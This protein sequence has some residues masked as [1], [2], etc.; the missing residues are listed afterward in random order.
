MAFTN[1]TYY[2]EFRDD[3]DT[4]HTVYLF[5]DG[6]GGSLTSLDGTDDPLVFRYGQQ[7]MDD[8][9]P[10]GPTSLE[11]SYIASDTTVFDDI[12]STTPMSWLV[13]WETGGSGGGALDGTEVWRGFL[14]TDEITREYD[15]PHVVTLY[16]VDGLKLLENI[17]WAPAAPTTRAPIIEVLADALGELTG[18]G[19]GFGTYAN[20]HAYNGGAAASG[21]SWA[22]YEVQPSAWSD[23]ETGDY[24]SVALACDNMAHAF[25]GHLTL[26]DGKW[27]MMQREA[28]AG[29]SYSMDI[30][31]S[32]GTVSGG[33]ETISRLE[34][35]T[36]AAPI[37]AGAQIQ[38]VTPYGSMSVRFEHGPDA[39][40][41][42]K[43]GNFR[44]WSGG[45]P[46]SWS[47]VDE[48][49]GTSPNTGNIVFQSDLHSAWSSTRG[50]PDA[51]SYSCGIYKDDNGGS[52]YDGDAVRTTRGLDFREYPTLGIEQTT[53]QE[54]DASWEIG[55]EIRAQMQWGAD[56]SGYPNVTDDYPYFWS[57]WVEGTSNDHYWDN[58]KRDWVSVTTGTIDTPPAA[59][60]NIANVSG[61]GVWNDF[62][63]QIDSLSDHS[64]SDTGPMTVRIYGP[65]E[66]TTSAGFGGLVPCPDAVL[67]D[68]ILVELRQGDGGY[69]GTTVT[70]QTD[71]SPVGR[72]DAGE[73][74]IYIGSNVSSMN[75]R[76]I[77]DPNGDVAGGWQFGAYGG[78]D[79]TSG[80]SLEKLRATRMM[81]VLASPRRR[82]R[83]NFRFASGSDD[84]WQHQCL[85]LDS[86]E[87][88]CTWLEH[89]VSHCTYSFEGVEV[90][91][92]TVTD[93]YDVHWEPHY[94]HFTRYDLNKVTPHEKGHLPIP[95]KGDPSI[96]PTIAGGALPIDPNKALSP[97]YIKEI[98]TTT[99]DYIL[100]ATGFRI[101][102]SSSKTSGRSI[103]WVDDVDTVSTEFLAIWSD[104]SNGISYIDGADDLG[105]GAL[106]IRYEAGPYLYFQDDKLQISSPTYSVFWPTDQHAEGDVLTVGASNQ[107]EWTPASVDGAA[108]DDT[109]SQA[110]TWTGI[111]IPGTLGATVAFGDLCYLNSSGVWALADADA[112][113][114]GGDVLLGM[115]LDA[116][117][118][119]DPT[120]MLLYG[121]IRAS[122][123]PTLVDGQV[124]Y[125]STTAGGFTETRPSATT[126]IVRVI[127][128][129]VDETTGTLLFAPSNSWAEVE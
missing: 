23:P 6:W 19:Y 65:V 113:N 105:G 106:R 33:P 14:L 8:F 94:A 98:G 118:N 59:S 43:N 119:T 39:L 27:R 10:L 36:A 78:G 62:T 56:P 57:V 60:K 123:F 2:L 87:Y 70:K 107:L 76:K 111:T 101:E 104:A 31:D 68:H 3:R 84:Y 25:A 55:I 17:T 81:N 93:P 38:S 95:P 127:G 129:C 126:D 5:E 63:E 24:A 18:H 34:I 128:Y 109:L 115:C 97:G 79:P 20:W 102:A 116:G 64:I 114:T 4:L 9:F 22:R 35:D 58:L 122:G 26:A 30:Y 89:R 46:V 71:G 1:A 99:R 80:I 92:I 32:D 54:L 120:T 110:G 121:T 44:S 72:P 88:R 85:L 73:R 29:A 37:L 125:V 52:Y 28:I 13:T 91:D 61:R 77:T 108:L 45:L 48:A 75:D 40:Y 74:L 41:A 11:I 117:V 7:R 53:A 124:Y 82:L 86:T 15:Y 51:G 21:N 16:A 50:L 100:D 83:A 90:T 42:I 112:E 66:V 67:V 103:R 49:P 12:Y 69:Q 47:E 96:Y